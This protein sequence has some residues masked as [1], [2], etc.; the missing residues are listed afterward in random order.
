MRSTINKV[1]KLATSTIRFQARAL[2]TTSKTNWN[3]RAQSFKNNHQAAWGNGSSWDVQHFLE[4]IGTNSKEARYWLKIFQHRDAN[5]EQPFAVL[6]VCNSVFKRPHMLNKLASSLAFLQRNGLTFILVIGQNGENTDRSKLVEQTMQLTDVLESQGAKTRPLINCSGV[7]KTEM[8]ADGNSLEINT[9]P[10]I[11]SL[12]TGHIPILSSLAETNDGQMV[13]VCPIRATNELAAYFKPLKVMYLNSKGGILNEKGRVVEQVNFP[14]DY[15][16]ASS[17]PWCDNR[18]YAKMGNINTLLQKLPFTSS[19]VIA[20]ADSVL[21]ELFTHRGSGTIFKNREALNAYSNF[22]EID[23]TKLVNLIERT[24]EKRLTD[25]YVSEIREKLIAAYITESY[26]AAAIITREEEVVGD[27]PY[28]DKFAVSLQNQGLGAG[29]TI[30][31]RIKQ[32]FP[33][34]FWRSRGSNRINPWYF[35]RSEGSWTNS[36]YTVFWYGVNEPK[37]SHEIV[38]FSIAHPSSFCEY[39]LD[40]G[41]HANMESTGKRLVNNST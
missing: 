35:T 7:L 36:S 6:Q 24:F 14:T 40:L 3:E 32:D 34:L 5:P 1:F 19:V 33:K 8:N 26:S 11:W 18:T 31:E 28:L 12:S 39:G 15:T 27:V 4:E 13:H 23:V 30:W 9:D 29:E 20:S 16:T 41:S 10:L 17:L 25:L 2:T 22:D 21:Q 37:L 38:N